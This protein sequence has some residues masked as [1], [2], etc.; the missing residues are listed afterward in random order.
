MGLHQGNPVDAET[1]FFLSQ[2]RK[3]IFASAYGHDKTIAT[4]LGRPPRLSHRYCRMEIPLDLSDQELFL[5][6]AELDTAL[7]SLD[8]NGWNTSGRVSRTTWQRVWFHY[9]RIREDILEIALGSGDEDISHQAEE[10]RF[11]LQRLDN[12]LP[13]FM[14][15]SPEDLLANCESYLGVNS[16]SGIGERTA[17]QVNAMFT[18]CIHAGIVQTQFL[19]QR[20]LINRQR[21]DTKELIPISRRML[22]LVLLAQSKRDYFRD[23]QGD[24]VWLVSS[25]CIRHCRFA[26]NLKRWLSTAFL[27]LESCLSNY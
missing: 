14:K 21:T 4:F 22:R 20:A 13:E 1:P 27:P 17:R 6:G 5:E 11:K 3:K 9:S 16:S 18:I 7:A 25:T 2:C 26:N 8:A 15:V 24:L 23:F 19:L 10:I 12:S